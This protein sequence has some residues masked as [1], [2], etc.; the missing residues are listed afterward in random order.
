MAVHILVIHGP[1]QTF[2]TREPE[3]YGV[4]TRQY[5]FASGRSGRGFWCPTQRVQSNHEGELVD[6][7]SCDADGVIINPAAF[8]Y[9]GCDT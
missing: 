3:V 1:N 7:S 4:D 8:A 9:V 2:G 6:K 5:P